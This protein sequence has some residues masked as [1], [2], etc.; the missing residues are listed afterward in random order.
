MTPTLELS[1]VSRRFP[2]SSVE[3]HALREV[4]L[5]VRP[6]EMVAV[7]G[8]SGSGKSTLLHI[9]AGLEIPTF[10]EVTLRGTAMPRRIEDRA[11]A[12]A[13][14]DHIGIVFQ[15]FN[16][17]PSFT[18]LENV[19]LPLELAGTARRR[20]ADAA[21]AAL[22]ACGLDGREGDFPDNLSGGQQQRVA[23]ARAVVGDRALLLA[24]EPTGALD[25]AAGDEVVELLADRAA[26]GAAVVL[27]THD[28]RIASWADRVVFLHDGR[29]VDQTSAPLEAE[30]TLR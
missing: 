29:I 21:R 25:S 14:R 11:W 5:V 26:A 3:V 19:A 27:A 8:R 17:L 4:D 22:A 30:V 9:A 7:M 13:R 24:D 28:T 6:G 1:R 16:L 20:A 23:I 2:G 10:G 18:V 15:R 12:V